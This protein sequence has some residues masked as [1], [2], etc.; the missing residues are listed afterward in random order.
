MNSQEYEDLVAKTKMTNELLDSIIPELSEEEIE[1]YKTNTYK[2][3][4]LLNK[5]KKRIELKDK[6][7]S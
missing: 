1:R 2:P 7:K 3:N 4:S 5:L 6:N